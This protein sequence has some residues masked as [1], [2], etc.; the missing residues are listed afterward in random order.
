MCLTNNKT[1]AI[2]FA[3]PPGYNVSALELLR[4]ELV[5]ASKLGYTLSLRSMF[6]VRQLSHMKLDLNSGQWSTQPGDGGFFPFSTDLPFAQ[7]G[8]PT[9]DGPSRASVFALHK[10]WTQV[11]NDS[12]PRCILS[13][14]Y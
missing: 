1:N 3:P 7:Y 10:W 5:S 11:R 2:P 6:L 14:A 8:W 13:N 12:V 9:G 4:R